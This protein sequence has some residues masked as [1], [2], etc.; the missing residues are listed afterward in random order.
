M[1][2][3]SFKFVFKEHKIGH[4]ECDMWKIIYLNGGV[5]YED[6]IDYRI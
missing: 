4:A 1:L 5:T 6:M 3:L 2:D